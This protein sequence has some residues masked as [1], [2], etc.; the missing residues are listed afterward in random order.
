MIY[1]NQV[2]KRDL[3]NKNLKFYQVRNYA[4]GAQ[5]IEMNEMTYCNE[6]VTYCNEKV[7]F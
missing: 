2:P 6:E 4:F 3:L 7:A 5:T 1:C